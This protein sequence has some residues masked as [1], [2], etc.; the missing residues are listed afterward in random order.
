MCGI[1]GIIASPVAGDILADIRTMTAAIAYRGPDGDGHWVDLNAGIALGHRRLAVLDLSSAG[2]QPMQSHDHRWVLS[3]NGEIYNYREL[4]QALERDRTVPWRGHS[5]TEVLLEA[6]SRWGLPATLERADGMFAIALWDRHREELHLV[7]DR[8]GEKPLYVGWNGNRILFASELKA[9]HAVTKSPFELGDSGLEWLLALGYVPAPWTPFSHVFKLPAGHRLILRPDS[10][11][12][13]SAE[14]FVSDCMPFWTPHGTAVEATRRSGLESVEDALQQVERGLEDS[15]S[16]RMLADVPL[17]A[18]LSGGIDSSLVTALMVKQSRRPVRTFTIGFKESGYDETEHAARVSDALGT[19][20]HVQ[21]LHADDALGL[22][23]ELPHLFDEPV[24]DASQLPTLLL[25]RYARRHVTVC[26][27]GDGGDE[28]FFGYQRQFNAMRLWKKISCVPLPLRLAAAAGL[29]KWGHLSPEARRQ[30]WRQASFLRNDSA[31]GLHAAMS[32]HWSAGGK[33]PM[34]LSLAQDPSLDAMDNMRVFDQRF[35]L[36][37]NLMTKTDRAAMSVGL[38]TR[39]PFLEPSLALLAMRL[40]PDMLYRNGHGKWLLRKLLARH[41]PNDIVERPKQGFGI[42]L[43][44]WL[45][46]DLREWA[47]ELFEFARDQSNPRVDIAALQAMW[48]AHVSGR[49]NY[50]DPLWTALT[51]L[52]WLRAQMGAMGRA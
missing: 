26:L 9:L 13:G 24:A 18:F 20:H 16:R 11:A 50:A 34:L 12:P 45:R 14:A 40:S 32:C 42:P 8:F 5:D 23:P 28:L 39:M 21:Y 46:T 52:N 22:I 17:G 49:R 35:Y 6:I 51:L 31:A 33:N 43:D 3:Y 7:R 44:A 25:S 37:D 36:A 29:T 47:S 38:E 4:R 41:V 10:R 15:I 27:S 48:R 1:V 30:R 19:E 2:A